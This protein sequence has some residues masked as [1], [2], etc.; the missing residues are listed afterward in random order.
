MIIDSDKHPEANIFYIGAKQLEILN[1]KNK[2]DVL[3][4][5][6]EYNRKNQTEI[7]FD[8]HMFG[9]DWLF[10]LGLVNLDPEGI[11]TVCF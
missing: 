1:K 9:L 3:S 11:I 10:L 4:L 2:H 6:K 7:S 8:Y 5:F